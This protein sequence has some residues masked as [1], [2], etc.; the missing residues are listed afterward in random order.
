[1]R[2]KA[3]AYILPRTHFVEPLSSLVWDPLEIELLADAMGSMTPIRQLAIR[4][5]SN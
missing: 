5:R 2:M 3:C 1:M 4:T